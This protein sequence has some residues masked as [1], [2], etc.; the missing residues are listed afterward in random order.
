MNRAAV[1][2]LPALVLA[3]L[4]LVDLP[5]SSNDFSW[6]ASPGVA[7]GVLPSLEAMEVTAG[8]GAT[9]QG[10]VFSDE[11]RTGVRAISLFSVPVG[12]RAALGDRAQVELRSHWAQGWM[13]RADDSEAT[14]QGPTDTQLRASLEL[15]PGIVTVTGFAV[16]PTGVD[17]HSLEEL[18]LAGAMAS[19]L[20]PFRISHWGAGGGGG[21]AVAF[22]RSFGRTGLGADV[23]IM[24]R[25]EFDLGDDVAGGFR[26]GDEFRASVVLDRLVGPAGKL[27][28]RLDGRFFGDSELEGENVF[29]SG[30]R[31]GATGSYSFPVGPGAS[32]VMYGG[33]RH[34]TEGV[35]LLELEGR[36]AQGVAL[37]GG[38]LRTPGMGGVLTPS[39][40]VRALRRDD[41]LDQ[42]YVVGLGG[43][44]EW[45]TR[46]ATLLPSLRFHFG[47]ILVTEETSSGFV[48]VDLS[49]Q[50]RLRGGRF[51]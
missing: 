25:G 30:D 8:T 9:F 10:F 26:P 7:Q 22:L 40:A 27:T 41:G 19:D 18:E 31:I 44:G 15:I 20:L 45:G 13:Q 49:L 4:G 48:G 14:I 38:A 43:G 36:P 21:A 1:A 42:G 3:T 17:A 11:E 32:A 2:W 33:Y 37:A 51:R 46:G 39:V 35:F 5:G 23:G 28:L 50:V 6:G 34:R 16:F 29:R 12:A 24:R 47:S